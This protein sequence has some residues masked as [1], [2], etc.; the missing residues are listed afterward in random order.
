MGINQ[1]FYEVYRYVNNT[2]ETCQG[3][4]V[5]RRLQRGREGKQKGRLS[6]PRGDG[7]DTVDVINSSFNSGKFS[8]KG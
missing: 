4:D 2:Q 7:G 8:D 6:A 3:I 1:R 5:G